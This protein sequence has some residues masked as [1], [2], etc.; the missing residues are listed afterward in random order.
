LNVNGKSLDTAIKFFFDAH[1][2]PA[3]LYQYSKAGFGACFLGNPGDPPDFNAVFGPGYQADLAWMEAYLARFPYSATAVRI[4]TILGS[5]VAAAPFPL[6]NTTIGVNATCGY[7][8]SLEFHPITGAKVAVVSGDG[9]T[10]GPGQPDPA[11]LSVLVTDSSGKAVAGVLVSFAV[12]QGSA[13]L[14][15]PAQVHTDATG[16]ASASVSVTKGRVTVTA[17]SLGAPAEFSLTAPSGLAI[18]SGGIAG[19]GGSVPALATVT[20]GAL[21]SIYGQN[22]APAGTGRRV[23]PD[24]LVR[25]A[26]PTTLLGVC[27]SVGGQSAPVLDVYPEQINAVAPLFIPNTRPDVVVT[28]G[29]GTSSAVQSVAESVN[30]APVSPEFLDLPITQTA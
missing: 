12:T 20:P 24:E 6:M 18:N 19:V 4:R 8:T 23:N 7:R 27:V 2:N 5:N 3:L 25:G 13:H 15:T 22:F 9:Q 11:P 30:F 26:L 1:D 29:C 21:F 28:T 17:T 14:S 10:A 16:L